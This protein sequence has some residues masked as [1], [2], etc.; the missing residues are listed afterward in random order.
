MCLAPTPEMPCRADSA[1]R[2]AAGSVVPP[3][4]PA[5]TGETSLAPTNG[6]VV[7]PLP[8]SLGGGGQ[9]GDRLGV[10]DV[11]VERSEQ[12]H[13]QLDPADGGKRVVWAEL[14]ERKAREG[15]PDGLAAEGQQAEDA[16]HASL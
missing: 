9:R 12:R 4:V 11:P 14:V 2:L 13:E 10:T 16:V 5:S 3:S 1:E 8:E 7:G 15:E 6:S